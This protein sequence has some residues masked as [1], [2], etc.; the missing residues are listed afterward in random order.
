MALSVESYGGIT[1]GHSLPN[2]SK[3]PYTSP[4]QYGRSKGRGLAIGDVTLIKHD[5]SSVI[6]SSVGILEGGLF[7]WPPNL[8]VL[9]NFPNVLDEDIPDDDAEKPGGFSKADRSSTDETALFETCGTLSS[10]IRT[11]LNQLE[12]LDICL[13]AFLNRIEQSGETKQ[14]Q[15]ADLLKTIC[16]AQ[17]L[18]KEL[19]GYLVKEPR[20]VSEIIH[21]LQKTCSEIVK[22]TRLVKRKK[23]TELMLD[24]DKDRLKRTT[25]RLCSLL[26]LRLDFLDDLEMMSPRTRNHRPLS[27]WIVKF[28]RENYESLLW[29]EKDFLSKD[30]L[31]LIGFDPTSSSVETVLARSCVGNMQRHID[32][33]EWAEIFVEDEFKYSVL[34]SQQTD[35]FPFKSDSVNTWFQQ[36]SEIDS[37]ECIHVEIMNLLTSENTACSKLLDRERKLEQEQHVVLFHGTDHESAKEIL[38]RGIDLKAGRQRRDFSC[39]FGFYLTKNCIDAVNWARSTTAKPAVLMFHVKR[40]CLNKSQIFLETS[41]DDMTKWHEIVSSFRSDKLTAD[42]QN[43]STDFDSIEG[44]A[45]II[46][47]RTEKDE[48][49]IEPKPSSHQICLFSDDIADKFH[50]SLHS[51]LFFL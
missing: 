49:I 3:L 38:V 24:E 35:K 7:E 39:G 10:P 9:K 25:V 30:L 20:K 28:L 22:R 45:S 18:I 31:F 47:G 5:P 44:P 46:T 50:K 36:S 15:F 43:L 1:F 29:S 40:R 41:D 16:K 12:I 19:Q 8:F 4:V 23:G 26:G 32:P 34:L 11:T 13:K 27:E 33:C 37:G 6:Q 2:L 14:K 21:R 51:I 42:I 17:R 48:L